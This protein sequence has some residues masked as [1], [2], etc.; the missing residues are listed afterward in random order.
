MVDGPPAEVVGLVVREVPPV[1]LVQ[2]A[3]GVDGAGADGEDLAVG[4]GAVGVD[5]VQ[6]GALLK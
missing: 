2:D 4:A 5:V 1:A 6:A 3:V